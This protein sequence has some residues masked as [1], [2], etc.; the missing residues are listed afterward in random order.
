MAARPR[1]ACAKQAHQKGALA[2]VGGMNVSAFGACSM[3][4]L[5]VIRVLSALARIVL[6]NHYA[7]I[8]FGNERRFPLSS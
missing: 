4:H 3:R 6:S 7:A 1:A 2:A 8:A 5:W